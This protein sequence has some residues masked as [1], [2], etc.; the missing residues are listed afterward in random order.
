MQVMYPDQSTE[1]D[2]FSLSTATVCPEAYRKTNGIRYFMTD[3]A[4][5]DRFAFFDIGQYVIP[6]GDG[7]AWQ[8]TFTFF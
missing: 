7:T 4:H 3:R 2:P 8:D 6:G 1:T 5:S